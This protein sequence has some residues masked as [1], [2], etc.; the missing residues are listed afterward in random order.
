M[1]EQQPTTIQSPEV[2]RIKAQ[3]ET[4]NRLK[5]GASWFYWIAGVSIINTLITLG[6]S[7][8]N[9]LIGL[10]ATQFIDAIALLI[11][12]EVNPSISLVIRGV[13]LVLSLTLAGLFILFGW[14][15]SKA[16]A[17]AFIIGMVFYALDAV[18]FVF[19]GSWLSVGL[20]VFAL[21]GIY[22]GWK[23]SQALQKIS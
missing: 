20:H 8:W 7:E 10:G 21:L 4:T 1:I 14:L 3:L 18:L 2:E 17:W 12:N 16:F 13:G 6:G 23:A 9:F 19:L 22:G 15:A 5:G 11:A